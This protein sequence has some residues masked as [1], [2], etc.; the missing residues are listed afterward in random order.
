MIYLIAV[1]LGTLGVFACGNHVHNRRRRIAAVTRRL[2]RLRHTEPTPPTC[3]PYWAA[4]NGMVHGPACATLPSLE[5]AYDELLNACCER[6]WTSLETD[7][8][9]T[10]RHQTRSSAA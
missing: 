9:P 10:C 4:S 8:D 1:I 3:C 5:T 2:E 6:W 7:H